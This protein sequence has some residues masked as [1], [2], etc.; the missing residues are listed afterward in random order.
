[1]TSYLRQNVRSVYETCR[2]TRLHQSLRFSH[3]YSRD[4]DDLGLWTQSEQCLGQFRAISNCAELFPIALDTLDTSVSE[5]K[6]GFCFNISCFAY[7]AC[8]SGISKN[9]CKFASFDILATRD[10]SHLH[11]CNNQ[12]KMIGPLGYIFAC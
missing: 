2:R 11:Q 5:P 6:G 10:S 8:M 3:T 12:I 4:V 7:M 1:M 9:D